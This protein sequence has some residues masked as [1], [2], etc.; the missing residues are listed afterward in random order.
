MLGGLSLGEKIDWLPHILKER[1][2]NESFLIYNKKATRTLGKKYYDDF[3]QDKKL[4]GEYIL[5]DST[6]NIFAND[7]EK[8][9]FNQ[10]IQTMTLNKKEYIVY[11]Y[12]IIDFNNETMAYIFTAKE[13]KTFQDSFRDK[14]FKDIVLIFLTALILLIIYRR[15]SIAV[16]KHLK[17]IKSITDNI[18]KREFN[19]LHTHKIKPRS[20]KMSTLQ[21]IEFNIIN[22]GLSLEEQYTHLEN[23]NKNKTT[24]L[25]MQLYEDDLTKLGNRNALMRDLQKYKGSYIAIFNTRGF[26]NINEAF[27]FEAGNH[28]LKAIGSMFKYIL[29]NEFLFYRVSNDEFVLINSNKLMKENF[30]QLTRK[31]IQEL[32]ATTL[33]YQN[34]DIKINIYVGICLHK[35]NRLEKAT[36][37]LTKAKENKLSYYIYN[38]N[39]DTKNI[40]VA[41]IRM[42]NK[43]ANALKNDTIVPYYQ[44]IVDQNG[45]I[46]KYESLVRLIENDTVLSPYQFLDISKKTKLY[47]EITKVVIE[48]TFTTFQNS[49]KQFSI[50]ITALDI[51]NSE[52]V[53]LIFEKLDTM[54]E[55]N[56]VI[57]ELVESDDLYN[58]PEVESFLKSIKEKGAKI[59]IDDFG[60]GYSNFS[61]IIKMKP[62]CLKI[63]GSLIKNIDSDIFSY[64]SVK[65]IINFAHELNIR[66]VAEFVHSEEVFGICKNLGVDEFQGYFF[67]EPKKEIF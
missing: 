64:K 12:P 47:T 15:N 36:V 55:C 32:E 4:I 6:I 1:T 3:L 38:G 50:N 63:D 44:P 66:V 45:S 60:T 41:N 42:L 49:D 43:I 53:K 21:E 57:F 29:S 61:H 22:M 2:N 46:N 8:I 37:A 26:K 9:D 28:I 27:G 30:V 67:S 20:L 5:A 59:A 51:L 54:K 25:I 10:N 56:Q 18:K 33:K 16:Q 65:T 23:D 62:D 40:Q 39:E 11:R 58:L 19:T 7:I 35:E 24:Q 17:D 14:I 31:M 13:L 34:I 52:V 48:K